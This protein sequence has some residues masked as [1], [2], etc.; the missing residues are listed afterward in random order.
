MCAMFR[1]VQCGQRL[2]LALK[3]GHAT[4]IGGER[5]WQDFD[6]DVALQT[7][8]ARAVHLAHPACADGGNDL[9][10]AEADSAGD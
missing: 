2:G 5:L 9:V 4:A 3:P 7:R 6:R 8:V 1:M 10:G